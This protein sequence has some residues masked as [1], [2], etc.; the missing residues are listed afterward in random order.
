MHAR[1]G[2]CNWQTYSPPVSH[3]L[4]VYLSQSNLAFDNSTWY[5]ITKKFC[6][7]STRERNGF[8]TVLKNILSE[9]DSNKN[10]IFTIDY[11]EWSRAGCSCLHFSVVK[12]WKCLRFI[13]ICLF[14]NYE[15]QNLHILRAKAGK[16]KKKGYSTPIYYS[17]TVMK[18]KTLKC[19]TSNRQT[20]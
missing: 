8:Q 9:Y 17:T 19:S 15:N 7:Y 2:N 11:D 10:E 4:S 5:P 20:N 18:R 1:N 14:H 13:C 3:Q 6:L 12:Y 16:S